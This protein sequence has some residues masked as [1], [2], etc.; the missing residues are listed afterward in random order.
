MLKR[1]FKGA[2]LRLSIL[3]NLASITYAFLSLSKGG[4]SGNGKLSLSAIARAL[5]AE[6]TQ[7]SRFKRLSRFLNNKSFSPSVVIPQLIFFVM[8]MPKEAFVPMVVDQTTIGGVQVIMTGLLFSGRVLPVGFICFL[9]EKIYKSQNFLEA[10]FMTLL[11]SVFPSGHK[12]IFIMDRYY[13]R[14]QMIRVL[15][16]IKGFY[17]MRAKSNVIMWIGGRA[18]ALSRFKYKAGKPV[19]YSN[20]M[21]RKDRQEAV[22][23]VIYYEKGFKDVWYLL[24]PVKSEGVLRTE[25]VVRLYRE[26]MQIEQG[27]RDWKT[28]LG[29]RGL[30]L[31][32]NPDV[33]LNRLLLSL[34]IA[35]ILLLLLGASSLGVSLRRRFESKRTKP[36]HGTVN[37]MSVLTLATAMLSMADIYPRVLRQLIDIIKALSLSSV[38]ELIKRYPP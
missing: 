5:Y 13:G 10:G 11:R 37:T 6:G 8:G 34:S 9:H 38:L 28:H 14:V 1:R 32:V 29:V 27:F 3:K 17:I 15:N 36:R 19:R 7:K 2:P 23:L 21:Y 25:E 26:R 31:Q 35:Y 16:T 12:P 24:V 4:R 22:D 20:V 18:R 30:K 33:R